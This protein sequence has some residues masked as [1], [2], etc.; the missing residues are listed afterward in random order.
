M[1]SSLQL[2]KIMGIPVRL[3]WTFLLVILY[4]AWAFASFSQ[5]VFGRT[6]GFGGIEPASCDGSTLCSLP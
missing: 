3:H 1:N 6:Y 4:V 5:P 2:G